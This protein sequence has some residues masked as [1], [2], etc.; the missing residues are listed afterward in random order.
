MGLVKEIPLSNKLVLE[1]WDHSRII[2][3][4]TT[5]VELSLKIKVAV[6]EEYFDNPGHFEMVTK[7]FGEEIVYEYRKERSFVNNNKKETIFNELLEDFTQSTLPYLD[8]P[9]FPSRF[10]LSKL[11]D[12]LKRPHRYG[13][14][15]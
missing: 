4:D 8:K 13:N 15:S 14:L 10:V 7:A 1:V 3:A 11:S 6:K 2:A 9:N 12:I 5:K